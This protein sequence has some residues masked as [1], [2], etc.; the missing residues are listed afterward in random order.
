MG[1]IC[2]GFKQPQNR[3]IT[4]L[5]ALEIDPAAAIGAEQVQFVPWRGGPDMLAEGWRAGAGNPDDDLAGWQFARFRAYRRR[6]AGKRTDAIDIGLRADALDRSHREAERKSARRTIVRDHEIFRPD[7][8]NAFT[9][10]SLET[11]GIAQ[12]HQVHWRRADEGGHE[13][14]GG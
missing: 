12:R 14:G 5:I 10:R 1:M 8:Q 2:R 4:R 3:S 6:V 11:A 9:A 7:A 13:G